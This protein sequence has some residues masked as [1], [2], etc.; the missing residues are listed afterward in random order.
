MYKDC[1]LPSGKRLHSYGQ[2]TIEIVNF[3]MNS[4][5]IFHSYVNVYQRVI[6]H[7]QT[8]HLKK[9]NNTEK[10]TTSRSSSHFPAH[11]NQVPWK[12]NLPGLV[13]EQLTQ[14]LGQ[15]FT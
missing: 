5:V 8:S 2:I 3:P 6:S 1:I 9:K 11:K 14:E 15:I 4:M 7:D 13:G 10:N 12:K